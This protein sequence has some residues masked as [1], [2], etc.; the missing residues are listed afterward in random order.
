MI[1]IQDDSGKLYGTFKKSIFVLAFLTHS[2]GLL[3]LPSI[4]PLYIVVTCV[5]PRCS[6]FSSWYRRSKH[7]SCW[8]LRQRLELMH[9]L[10]QATPGNS[11]NSET[12]PGNPGNS[13]KH[14]GDCL[15]VDECRNRYPFF[16]HFSGTWLTCFFNQSHQSLFKEAPRFNHMAWLFGCPDAVEQ[17]QRLHRLQ[18]L[19]AACD[20]RT[21][22]E[23]RPDAMSEPVSWH[24]AQREHHM[25]ASLMDIIWT[26]YGHPL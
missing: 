2:C 24:E 11:E 26:L 1:W 18:R 4:A 19:Q 14:P 15:N 10:G 5:T 8:V 23:S 16:H 3:G 6:I 17:L 12:N 22:T 7:V 9:Y 13:T 25:G 20:I 21:E